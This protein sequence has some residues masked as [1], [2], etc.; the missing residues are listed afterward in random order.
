MND[1]PVWWPRKVKW[2]NA[3][4]GYGQDVFVHISTV[5]KVAIFVLGRAACSRAHRYPRA[6]LVA[7][8]FQRVAIDDAGLPNEIIRQG[9]AGGREEQQDGEQ[10]TLEAHALVVL[11]M[12]SQLAPIVAAFLHSRLDLIAYCNSCFSSSPP[13]RTD[14]DR[15]ALGDDQQV[16]SPGIQVHI[17]H[18]H[19]PTHRKHNF[20]AS[21]RESPKCNSLMNDAACRRRK[22]GPYRMLAWR[23]A[24]K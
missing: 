9:D 15:L 1:D 16:V 5:E 21:E 4:K 13:T 23:E 8:D 11:L 22:T 20:D 19:L 7:V 6:G 18:P 17:K 24:C 12:F 3:A 10:P 14:R 2:F